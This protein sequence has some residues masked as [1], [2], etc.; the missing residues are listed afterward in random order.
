MDPE[1]GST[2]GGRMS[3][4]IESSQRIAARVVGVCYL[5]AM[6]A[7]IFS[8]SFVRAKLID[9]DN[10]TLTAQ[11]LIAHP[12]LFRLSAA[13]E[14]LTFVSDAVLV[15]SL[16]LILAPVQRY[17]A[18]MA[19]FLRMV[20]VAVCAVMAAGSF[21]VLR[22]LSGAPYLNAFRP[23]QLAV[24]ARLGIGSHGTAYNVAFVFLGLGSTLFGVLWLR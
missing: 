13:S 20:E 5:F 21:D 22:V 1:I 19:A 2:T 11:H 10:A 12:G 14:L 24:L 8:E 3:D 23:D 6:V 15:A 4:G 16:Y 9:A 7:A 17:L 18:Q